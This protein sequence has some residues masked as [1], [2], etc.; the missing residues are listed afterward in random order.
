[1]G[2]LYFHIKYYNK[3]GLKMENHEQQH[4]KQDNGIISDRS[5]IDKQKS[6][7]L[8]KIFLVILS[9]CI[10]GY[11]LFFSKNIIDSLPG[12]LGFYFPSSVFVWLIFYAIFTRKKGAK[13]AGISFI[14]IYVSFM[15]SGYLSVIM[16][17]IEAKKAITEIETQFEK[18]AKS[19][20][21]PSGIPERIQEEIQTSPKSKGIVGE[22]ERF[23][24]TFMAR[25]VSL[26]N[27][28]LLEL[29]AVGLNKILDPARIKNDKAFTESKFI[30]NKSKEIIEKYKTLTNSLIGEDA[31]AEI[32][33][34]EI[35]DDL[36]QEMKNGFKSGLEPVKS[37]LDKNWYLDDKSILEFE[38]IIKLLSSHKDAWTI[39]NQQILF[40]NE[41]DLQEFNTYISNIQDNIKEQQL[42]H[43]QSIDQAEESL[44]LMRESLK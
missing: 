43:Q 34:L 1:M 14:I 8:W 15:L 33:R 19:S 24:K 16:F 39:E 29:N 10:L 44:K 22:M 25:S 27:D 42:I 7:N 37:M 13:I 32:D 30:I 20:D 11:G 12:L 36:K 26:R 18:I 38:K 9:I 4:S 21:S 5:S 3:E 41:N 23:V 2:L 28:Y 17:E 6:N 31:F 40:Y 35:D